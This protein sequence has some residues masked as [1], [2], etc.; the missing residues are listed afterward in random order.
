[1]L[2]STSKKFG[3]TELA[4]L[5]RG[6]LYYCANIANENKMIHNKIMFF[7][8]CSSIFLTL[9]ALNCRTISRHE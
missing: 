7:N 8:H 2:P 3:V 1:M 4:I 5:Y 6:L 9:S